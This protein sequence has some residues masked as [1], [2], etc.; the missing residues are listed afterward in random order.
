MEYYAKSAV[1]K[2]QEE[3]RAKS[4]AYMQ[5]IVENMPE[6]LTESEKHE[7]H[8]AI[9]DLNNDKKD[10]HVTLRQHLDDIVKYM[11]DILQIRKRSWFLR[12]ADFM[13]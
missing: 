1:L 9:K 2:L 11:A 4:A 6:L 7:V 12:L 13:I 3:K 10:V 5:K 8:K